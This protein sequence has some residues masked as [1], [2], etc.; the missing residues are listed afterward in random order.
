VCEMKSAPR[1]LVG[2]PEGNVP[3]GDFRHREERNIKMDFQYIICG[4]L[5]RCLSLRAGSIVWSV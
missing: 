2:A 1:I 5:H 4:I 3:F